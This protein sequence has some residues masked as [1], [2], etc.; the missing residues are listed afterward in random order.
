MLLGRA[1]LAVCREKVLEGSR[2]V[3][4]LLEVEGLTA[5]GKIDVILCQ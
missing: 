2:S 5:D 1:L 3:L 4:Q